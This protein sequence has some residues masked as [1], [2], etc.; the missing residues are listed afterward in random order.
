MNSWIQLLARRGLGALVVLSTTGLAWAQFPGEFI[1]GPPGSGDQAGRRV[2]PATACADGM[3]GYV[4]AGTSR[5]GTPDTDIYVV[6]T[7]PS[8]HRIWEFTYDFDGVGGADIGQSIAALKDG[9]GFV[10]TGSTNRA[11]ADTDA[12][13]MKINCDGKVVWA[14]HFVSPAQRESGYDVVEARTGNAAAGT[15]PGDI[16][17]AGY[18]LNPANN[19]TDGLLIRTRANGVLIWNR[20]YDYQGDTQFLRALT[21]ARPLGVPTGDVVAVGDVRSGA[22]TPQAF[23]L[24]V[25]GDTGLF[26]AAQHCAAARGATG[27][28][29]RFEAVIELQVAPYAGTLVMAGTTNT[30]AWGTDIYLVRTPANPCATIVQRHAG[31]PAGGP[32]GEEFALGLREVTSPLPI[33]PVGSLALTGRAGKPG[34]TTFDAFLHTAHPGSLGLLPGTGRLYGDH[35]PRFDAGTAILPFGNGFVIAGFS[36]SD[37]QGVGDPRDVYLV[38]TDGGG[39]TGC[40]Q[41]WAPPSTYVNFPVQQSYP[42]PVPFLQ[43]VYRPVKVTEE[44]TEYESCP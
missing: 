36:D 41:P 19:T 23:A 24:R 29:N 15:A 12:F 14:T 9:S 20:R 22:L 43:Q 2:V 8:G 30:T 3:G 35:G 17:I 11:T 44:F 13:L 1:Y 16:L 26:S 33:A 38:G 40:E 6:R 10:V 42:Y 32:L 7:K 37:F 5:P 4:T 18:T 39:K 21:E 27:A 31:D 34:S 25:N 28:T